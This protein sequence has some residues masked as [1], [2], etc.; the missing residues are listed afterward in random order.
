MKKSAFS[1]IELLIVIMII[2]VVYTLAIGN[3]KKLSDETSKLT[4]GNLKEYLHSIKHSKSVKLMCLDDCSECDLYVDGKKS[5]TVEDFLD[6]SVKVYR[7]EFSY[8]IVE[9]EKEVYFNIDNVEESVCF[10]YEIDKSG[11]GDQVIVEYK[12]RVYD[13]SNYFTKTAVYNSV[14]DAVNAREELIR[15]VMQ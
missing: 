11:I 12:E 15:E 7:Y 13:F 8:G 5:R 1:L 10:S 2:G 3:F 4:L 14:E 6:N 9:R